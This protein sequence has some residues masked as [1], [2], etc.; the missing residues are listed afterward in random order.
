MT[1]LSFGTSIDCNF[2]SGGSSQIKEK[3]TISRDALGNVSMEELLSDENA[4]NLFN[5]S[6]EKRVWLR[7]L[8]NKVSSDRLQLMLRMQ[9]TCRKSVWPMNNPGLKE[10]YEQVG[11]CCVKFK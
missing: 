6:K 4:G 7:S 8:V 10:Y 2:Q 11:G 3:N 9:C 5:L 1:A